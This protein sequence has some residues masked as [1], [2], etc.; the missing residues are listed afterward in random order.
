MACADEAYA[1]LLS[2]HSS[3]VGTRTF[4]A[5]PGHAHHGAKQKAAAKLDPSF[6]L[7]RD[8]DLRTRQ[9]QLLLTLVRSLRRVERCRR[10]FVLM[11]GTAVTLS[12]AHRAALEGEGVSF[13]A[14]TCPNAV[15]PIAPV[16]KPTWR[17]MFSCTL[18]NIRLARW[19]VNR[20]LNSFADC[21]YSISSCAAM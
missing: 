5:D 10:D 8:G 18:T 2:V 16:R 9:V 17:G 11:L 4:L 3:H 19:I 20:A 7:G 13:H 1:S 14:S 6:Y 21:A 12:A 15:L